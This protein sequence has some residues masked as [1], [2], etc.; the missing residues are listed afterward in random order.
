MW[1]GVVEDFGTLMMLEHVVMLPAMLL[2]MLLR[3]DEYARGHAHH[4]V[5]A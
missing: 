4:P 2:A 3:Y 5:A 1:G